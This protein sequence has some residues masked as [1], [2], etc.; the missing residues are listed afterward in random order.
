MRGAIVP[1]YLSILHS[2]YI[3]PLPRFYSLVLR[4][5]HRSRCQRYT[6]LRVVLSKSS[7]LST[8]CWTGYVYLKNTFV[9]FSVS[10]CSYIT[11]HVSCEDCF[12]LADQLADMPLLR[13]LNLLRRYRVWP[14]TSRTIY[15]AIFRYSNQYSKSGFFCTS[16]P[17][18]RYMTLKQ[19]YLCL[20]IDQDSGAGIEVSAPA[21]SWF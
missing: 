14:K 13:H 1:Q 18:D 4:L 12:L 7:L 5:V 19:Y 16:V 10:S 15:H 11:W 9:I 3:A 21:N 20:G 6:L 8:F 17:H 2:S